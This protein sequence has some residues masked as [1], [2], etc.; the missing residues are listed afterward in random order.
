MTTNQTIQKLS[1]TQ[2]SSVNRQVLYKWHRKFSTELEESGAKKGQQTE[3]I[4][5]FSRLCPMLSGAT[6]DVR[7][8]LIIRPLFYRISCNF[9]SMSGNKLPT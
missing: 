2:Y 6:G 1:S 9:N 4:K 5:G 8:I 7:K 3:Q